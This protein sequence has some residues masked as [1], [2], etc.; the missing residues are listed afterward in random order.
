MLDS[1][2]TRRSSGTGLGLAI[3]KRLIEAMGGEIGVESIHGKGSRFW[4]KVELPVAKKGT[5]R[6][7]AL[8][9]TRQKAP[10]L[11]ILL[12]D[13]NATNRLVGSKLLQASGHD[14]TNATNGKE[15]VQMV[16]EATSPFDLIFMDISMPELDGVQATQ[17]IRQLPHP[18]CRTR[19]I[20]LTA[21]AIAGDRER[22]LAS[23][24]DGY[25]T[26]PLKKASIT[27]VLDEHLGV[28]GTQFRSEERSEQPLL[29]REHLT[30]LSNETSHEVVFAVVESY[31]T[32]MAQRRHELDQA[33]IA[34]CVDSLKRC[35]HAIAGASA[36]VGAVR[37]KKLASDIEFACIDKA[38]A[39]FAISEA[40]GP[41]MDET[42]SELQQALTDIAA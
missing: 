36:S 29:D 14:V 37:I 20:A 3:S 22:F 16:T 2:F 42:L 6:A 40:V 34:G 32:E 35:A 28:A 31:L 15:A 39:A 18:K 26:K 7:A 1:S 10:R 4:F 8:T 19:I 17:L 23:G 25:L 27:A 12:V 13:D 5:P 30:T 21:N 11:N 33:V 24:L 41:I 9:E 38:D